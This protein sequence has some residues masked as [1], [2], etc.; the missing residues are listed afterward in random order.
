MALTSMS[1]RFQKFLFWI[2]IEISNS[3]LIFISSCPGLIEEQQLIFI[4]ILREL[5]TIN[6]CIF[7]VVP[8]KANIYV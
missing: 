5:M 2:Q 7:A 8:L 4:L 3:L 6:R 1:V